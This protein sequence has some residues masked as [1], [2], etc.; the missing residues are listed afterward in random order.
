MVW[1][2]APRRLIVLLRCL[3]GRGRVEIK[4]GELQN[5]ISPGVTCSLA[6]SHMWASTQQ[7]HMRY[8]LGGWHRAISGGRNSQGLIL[9]NLKSTARV[10][11]TQRRKPY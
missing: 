8:P 4:A 3:L 5:R 2:R 7:I 11:T 1:K 6:Q 10:T 9:T